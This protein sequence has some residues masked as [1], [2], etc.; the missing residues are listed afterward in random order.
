M[1]MLELIQAHL[2]RLLG[3][4]GPFPG[5]MIWGQIGMICPTRRAE[6]FKITGVLWATV[7]KNLQK[8]TRCTVVFLKKSHEECFCRQLFHLCVV[9]GESEKPIKPTQG[10]DAENC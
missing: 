9:F 1:N 6:N 10:S 8:S 3:K 4:V 7:Q 2:K 5:C